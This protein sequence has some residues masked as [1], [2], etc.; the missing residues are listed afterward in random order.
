MLEKKLQMNKRIVQQVGFDPLPYLDK[1]LVVY[2][3]ISLNL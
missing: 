3:Y 1:L 2:I